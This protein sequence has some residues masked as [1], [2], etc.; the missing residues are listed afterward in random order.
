MRSQQQEVDIISNN[1][2]FGQRNFKNSS[3]EEGGAFA[4]CMI[5]KMIDNKFELGIKARLYYLIS[6]NTF[7]TLSLT[8]TLAY[9]F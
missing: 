4:G 6:T 1:I 7:E 9:H 3:L 2:S 8:P 5:S